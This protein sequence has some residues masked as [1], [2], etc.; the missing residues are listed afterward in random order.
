[1]PV[2]PMFQASIE[3]NLFND[4]EQTLEMMRTMIALMGRVD[5][6]LTAIENNT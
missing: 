6:R 4:G 2:F 1:M 3:K 5:I